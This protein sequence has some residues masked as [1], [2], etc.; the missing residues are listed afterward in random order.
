MRGSVG[1][2]VLSVATVVL[3]LGLIAA[4]ILWIS[5]VR[6]KDQESATDCGVPIGAAWHGRQSA[7]W[8]SVGSNL[9]VDHSTSGLFGLLKST[10]LTTTVCAGAARTRVAVAG[11]VIVLAIGGVIVGRRRW[12]R[13]SP[14]TAVA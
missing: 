1:R 13:S 5:D 3:A 14:S 11:G 9:Q 4:A 2:Q 12:G 6:F 7:T 8:V 10:R